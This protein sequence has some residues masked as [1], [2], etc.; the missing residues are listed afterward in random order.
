MCL[1]NY[2]S[3]YKKYLWIFI[4]KLASAAP[5]L[6]NFNSCTEDIF[7]WGQKTERLN[8]ELTRWWPYCCSPPRWTE[9]SKKLC[10]RGRVGTASRSKVPAYDTVHKLTTAQ[11][12]SVVLSADTQHNETEPGKRFLKMWPFSCW[13][14][15]ALSYSGTEVHNCT[16][17]RNINSVCRLL[18][19]AR[20][21][22][23]VM[24]K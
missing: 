23:N 2:S 18:Y 8:M 11:Q 10:L 17:W 12:H 3:H 1:L 4:R 21:V 9:L 22:K 16:S 7:F 14:I 5:H 13:R 20:Q 24:H 15:C 19:T 6:N